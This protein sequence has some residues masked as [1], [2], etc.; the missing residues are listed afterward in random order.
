[1]TTHDYST[2]PDRL[3]ERPGVG[4]V[5]VAPIRVD[6]RPVGALMGARYRATELTEVEI[7]VAEVLAAHLGSV[8]TALERERRQAELLVRAG[9][10]DE[11]RSSLIAAV[12]DEVRTPIAAVADAAEQLGARAAT[13]G[14]PDDRTVAALARLRAAA[15]ELQTTVTAVLSVA[16][17]RL[18]GDAGAAEVVTLGE[19]VARFTTG[20][21]ADGPAATPSAT[22]AVGWEQRVEVVCDLVVHA[23]E[24]LVGRQTT[25][26]L[27]TE[28]LEVANTDD[29]S[30]LTLRPDRAVAPS[31]VV[32]SL[33]AQLLT[34]AGAELVGTQGVVIRLQ[35]VPAG[36]LG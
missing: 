16:R 31:P 20:P 36:H 18:A 25:T 1:M 14:D 30:T 5:V 7:E 23:V 33:A 9:R 8:L 17:R 13:P 11:L 2:E 28:H 3:D 4:P 34:A 15:A 32:R 29:G 35:R 21:A 19:L 26:A 6:G 27:T 24:L 22:D 10:L 12:S